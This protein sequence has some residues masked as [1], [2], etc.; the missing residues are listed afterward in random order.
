M[1]V[2]NTFL[3]NDTV[4]I[5]PTLLFTQVY[6]AKKSYVHRYRGNEGNLAPGQ[7]E[8]VNYSGP[9]KTVICIPINF[10]SSLDGV[11]NIFFSVFHHHPS[12]LSTIFAYYMQPVINVTC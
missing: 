3:N 1:L 10:M 12:C 9:E 8:V 11:G 6:L 5:K 7:G 2:R 4:N